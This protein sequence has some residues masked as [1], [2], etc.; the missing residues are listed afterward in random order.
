MTKPGGPPAA[1]PA[2]FAYLNDQRLST[3]GNI[4]RMPTNQQEWGSFI[5]ELDKW[6]KNK[7]DGFDVGGSNTAQYFGFSSDPADSTVWWQRYGQV[8][9][10]RF[11]G[12]GTGT[13]NS[14]SFRI[15]TIPAE[16]TPRE[17]QLCLMGGVVDNGAN[18]T[19]ACAVGIG[20]DGNINFYA[21][22][23]G[24]TFTA[25]GNKGL[26]TLNSESW[27][28]TYLLRNPQQL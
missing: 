28:V 18:I 4:T 25:S 19:T 8:I 5:R 11:E 24:G 12:L 20:D 22:T 9:H 7:T 14:G 26:V 2:D 21:N 3:N 17:T 27:G 1:A 6:V 13:S 10:L 23:V 15:D 16:I